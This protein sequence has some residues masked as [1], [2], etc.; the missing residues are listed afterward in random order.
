[1]LPEHF[2]SAFKKISFHI[3]HLHTPSLYNY[4]LPRATSSVS[5]PCGRLARAMLQ[6][7]VGSFSIIFAG[8]SATEGEAGCRCMPGAPG[9]PMLSHWVGAWSPK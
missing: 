2:R 8:G 1:M 3:Q 5:L 6:P 7:T 4:A 9:L